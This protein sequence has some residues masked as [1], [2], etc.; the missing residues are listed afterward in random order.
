MGR[1]YRVIRTCRSGE[2]RVASSLGTLAVSID[3][4]RYPLLCSPVHIAMQVSSHDRRNDRTGESDEGLELGCARS[5]DSACVKV[6]QSGIEG[7]QDGWLLLFATVDSVE[8][9]VHDLAQLDIVIG[10][11]IVGT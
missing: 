7:G 11:V 1:H 3:P 6:A 8:V 4:S 5:G 9:S 10:A 2:R